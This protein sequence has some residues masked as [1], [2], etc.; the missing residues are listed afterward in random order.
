V[1]H[2]PFIA[3]AY[4]LT[5]LPVLALVGASVLAMRKAEAQADAL[6]GER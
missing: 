5:I 4:A 3:G 2:W 6:K 1:N